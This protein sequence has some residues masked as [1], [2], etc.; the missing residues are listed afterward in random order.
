MTEESKEPELPIVTEEAR[1]LLSKFLNK[2]PK[3]RIS[4]HEAMKHKWFLIEPEELE[5]RI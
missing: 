1:D 2:N 4:L 3:E 5:K